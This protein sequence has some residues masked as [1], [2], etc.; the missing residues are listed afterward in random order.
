MYMNCTGKM[1]RVGSW[2][3]GNFIYGKIEEKSLSRGSFRTHGRVIGNK[4]FFIFG[5]MHQLHVFVCFPLPHPNPQGS[6]GKVGHMCHV[7]N[8]A[9]SAGWGGEGKAWGKIAGIAITVC[10]DNYCGFT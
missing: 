7:F 8:F 4:N 9:S 10:R 1:V 2:K 5:F 3:V 6:I